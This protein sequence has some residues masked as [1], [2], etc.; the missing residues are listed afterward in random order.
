MDQ[1]DGQ[2]SMS[3]R[4]ITLDHPEHDTRYQRQPRG[5]QQH[6]RNNAGEDHFRDGSARALGLQHNQQD[7]V[8]RE[9]PHFTQQRLHHRSQ[10]GERILT[11]RVRLTGAGRVAMTF[12]SGVDDRVIAGDLRLVSFRSLQ[13]IKRLNRKPAATAM[14]SAMKGLSFT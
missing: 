1:A 14:P 6:C 11:R 7:V 2:K 3:P 13:R 10:S 5:H 8:L 9:R 4:R 12:G